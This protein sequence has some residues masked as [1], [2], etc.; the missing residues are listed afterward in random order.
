MVAW[1]RLVVGGPS[2]LAEDGIRA[3]SIEGV[4]GD[5]EKLTFV[6]CQ[7]KCRERE[8]T[9]EW[10]LN[11]KRFSS[12]IHL[13]RLH[14]RVRRVIHNMLNPENRQNSKELL[15]EES[16]MRRR[17]LSKELNK[18]PFVKSLKPWKG[19]SQFNIVSC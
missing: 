14:A 7:N 5:D 18:K 1:A 9:D 11:P 12:W 6:S 19:K 8:A 3:S 15:P 10:R 16:E 13:V 17:K 4:L 2:K